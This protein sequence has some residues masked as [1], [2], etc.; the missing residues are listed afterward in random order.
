MH[1]AAWS[2]LHALAIPVMETAAEWCAEQASAARRTSVKGLCS[3]CIGLEVDAMGWYRTRS[4]TSPST[5]T[6]THV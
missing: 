3:S 6:C 1:C 2:L 5:S 4:R